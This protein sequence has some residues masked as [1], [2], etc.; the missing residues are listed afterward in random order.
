MTEVTRHNWK[1]HCQ[2]PMLTEDEWQQWEAV[3]K[4]IR[5]DREFA[6]A[7]FEATE[8]E[9]QAERAAGKLDGWEGL[10][11]WADAS[12]RY[13]RAVIGVGERLNANQR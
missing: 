2:E 6:D 12:R 4:R 7:V 1:A 13:K 5:D 10:A 11:R 3:A 9:W 8:I